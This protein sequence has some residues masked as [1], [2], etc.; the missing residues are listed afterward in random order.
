MGLEKCL[1][2][3]EGSRE[4]LGLKEW[5]GSG[6]CISADKILC[7]VLGF[8]E[9]FGLRVGLEDCLVSEEGFGSGEGFGSKEGLGSGE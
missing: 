2:S 1:G 9:C 6:E 7:S 5:L 8:I 3:E 4:N